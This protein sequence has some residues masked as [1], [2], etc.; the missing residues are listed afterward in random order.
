[1]P[2]SVVH[3][4]TSPFFQSPIAAAIVLPSGDRARA[5]LMPYPTSIRWSTFPVA[6]CQTQTILLWDRETRVL[7]SGLKA[8]RDTRERSAPGCNKR[9]RVVPLATSHRRMVWSQ[10]PEARVLPSG[11]NASALT[12][13]V[14]PSSRRICLPVSASQRVIAWSL[15]SPAARILPLGERAK[16]LTQLA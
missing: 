12:S 15:I 6:T 13:P 10:A 11:V 5:R 2:V 1:W 7:P 3:R 9:R 14:C 8:R 16:A 4:R